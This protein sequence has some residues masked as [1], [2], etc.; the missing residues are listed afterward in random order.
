[1]TTGCGE[2]GGVRVRVEPCP[3]AFARAPAADEVFAWVVDLA[4]PPIPA[5]ELFRR[6]TADERARA[7]RYLIATVREQFVIGR[8]LL[9]GLLGDCLGVAPAAVPLA[10][11]PTGKPVLA[12]ENPALHFN[13]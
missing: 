11:L 7:A 12:G 2:A 3:A 4:R 8:G 1:M 10:Q 9:R 13:V 6:L 5:D